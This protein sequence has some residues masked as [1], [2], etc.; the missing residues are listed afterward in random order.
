MDTEF[1]TLTDEAIK[2]LRPH[3]ALRLSVRPSFAN[4]T[5]WALRR[6]R[7]AQGFQLDRLIWRRDLDGEKFR[8]PI[9]RLAYP[10]Q[11]S[12]TIERESWLVDV[13]VGEA[14]I[15]T[16]EELRLPC[17]IRDQSIGLDGTEY[18]YESCHGLSR[19]AIAWWEQA[20]VEWQPLEALFHSTRQEF[21]R[22]AGGTARG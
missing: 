19:C 1:L 4:S 2:L 13:P 6:T 7:D 9:E 17:L 22:M 15:S 18:E 21:E 16:F 10:R 3:A 5:T 14:W 12:P 20:P 8:S 11:L